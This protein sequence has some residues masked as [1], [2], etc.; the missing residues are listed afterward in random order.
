MMRIRDKLM[1]VLG[2]AAF[3]WLYAILTLY[4]D[5]ELVKAV[6]VTHKSLEHLRQ[7]SQL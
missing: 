7:V 4:D 3:W 1:N 6:L 2:I 5:L